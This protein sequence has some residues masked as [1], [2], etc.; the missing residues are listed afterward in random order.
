MNS[1][2]NIFTLSSSSTTLEGLLLPS[3][4]LQLPHSLV[5]A[6]QHIQKLKDSGAAFPG[7]QP[8][9]VNSKVP[10]FLLV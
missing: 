10:A 2:S 1:H 7:D 6:Y 8:V 9:T 5:H 4:Q 3:L